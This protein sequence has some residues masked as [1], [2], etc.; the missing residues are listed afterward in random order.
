MELNGAAFSFEVPDTW[1][2]VPF[3]GMVVASAPPEY[4]DFRPTVVL[5]ESR[6]DDAGPTTLASIAQMALRTIPQETPGAYVVHVEAVPDENA[7]PGPQERRRI[8]ALAPLRHP[9]NDL[10][11]LVFVQDHMV[12]GNAV[13]E[14]TI[15]LPVFT[16]QCDNSFK[17]ILDSLRPS[18][19]GLPSRPMINIP[20]A[21]LDQWATERDGVPREDVTVQGYLPPVLLG[22]TYE[23]STG[24]LNEL[25]S[26]S[27]AGFFGKRMRGQPPREELRTI[28]F[29][30]DDGDPTERGEA[31]LGVLDHG[32][33]WSLE[34]AG[35]IEDSRTVEGW[36]VEEAILTF[37]GP[38]ANDQDSSEK[39]LLCYCAADDLA[40]VL[41]MW[42]G[43]QP[44]WKMSFTLPEITQKELLGRL[45]D[46]PFPQQLEGDAAA[47]AAERWQ[48]FSFA[49]AAGERGIGWIAT[50]HRG[51]ALCS[52]GSREDG[53]VIASPVGQTLWEY[54]SMAAISINFGETSGV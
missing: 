44:S 45:I 3:E 7:G 21:V 42:S 2:R 15:T 30:D 32:N 6:V 47:F 49:D 39:G 50:P 13:A 27:S 10:L 43:A 35:P 17:R 53:I 38:A 36:G 54:L 1:E 37:I 31:L 26:L 52:Q 33:Y 9:A 23:L 22:N 29:I 28:G 40:R 34:N 48:Q 25:K 19:H 16:W 5:T 51:P 18:G 8:W 20:E 4:L 24:A 12:A 41:L 11:G 46:H 14:L